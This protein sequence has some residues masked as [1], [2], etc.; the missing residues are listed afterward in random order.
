MSS[1]SQQTE[2][3]LSLLIKD[4][5]KQHG[6]TQAHLSQSLQAES[7]RMQTIMEALKKEYL[8]GGLPKI[9]SKLCSIEESWEQFPEKEK[10]DL[11][12]KDPFDQLD[13]LLKDISEDCDA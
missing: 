3:E 11:S 4:W 6:R 10:E 8:H 12:E 13:L 5:L 2:E 9:A 7:S 1:W